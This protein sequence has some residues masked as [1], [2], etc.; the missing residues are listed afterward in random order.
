MTDQELI[1]K[2][3]EGS[4]GFRALAA[5]RIEELLTESADM[6]NELCLIE[7]L[8]TK[9]ADMRNELCLKC[10]RFKI[11]H[12]GACDGCRWKH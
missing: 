12:A 7:E 8:L 1:H 4:C 3:R 9:S 6:R 11:A 10:G 5:D 2:M